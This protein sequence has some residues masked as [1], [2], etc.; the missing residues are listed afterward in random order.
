MG[1]RFR[2]EHTQKVDSKGRV[3]IPATF[4]RVIESSDPD[5]VEGKPATLIIVYGTDELRDFLECYTVEAMDQIDALI[6]RMP[7][8][9]DERRAMEDFFSAKSEEVAVDG[10]GR[11]V[12]QKK[13]RDRIGIDGDGMAYFKA[14][15]DT[16]QIWNPEV[17]ETKEQSRIA[18]VYNA[19][20]D[21][22][23]PLTILDRYREA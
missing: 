6:E 23:D 17:Y 4:R 11:L 2:G 3:S 16:F 12:L 8:G 9:S 5:W 22:V 19:L 1:R 20:P 15:G 18:G 7:R 21:G 13:L 10:T 14:S